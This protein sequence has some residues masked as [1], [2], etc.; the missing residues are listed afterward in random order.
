MEGKRCRPC[1]QGAAGQMGE[2]YNRDDSPWLTLRYVYR[3]RAMGILKWSKLVLL[4]ED[5][6]AV[7]TDKVMC[8]LGLNKSVELGEGGRHLYEQKHGVRTCLTC[9]EN[10]KAECDH[11][12]R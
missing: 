8:R 10:A 11:S 4:G 2:K 9:L 3:F 5:T 12:I 6:G 1:P 7:F